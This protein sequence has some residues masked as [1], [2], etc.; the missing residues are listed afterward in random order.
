MDLRDV[1]LEISAWLMYIYLFLYVRNVEIWELGVCDFTGL[2]SNC[3]SQ[4]TQETVYR[5]G[6]APVVMAAEF[7]RKLQRKLGD[8]LLPGVAGRKLISAPPVK[9]QRSLLSISL[10]WM[11]GNRS[12]SDSVTLLLFYKLS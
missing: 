10:E 2:Q 5:Q 4:P 1:R 8:P 9:V 11:L 6:P 3:A 7:T 12:L